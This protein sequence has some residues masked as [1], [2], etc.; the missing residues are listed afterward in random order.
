MLLQ[1]KFPPSPEYASDHAELTVNAVRD[2]DGLHLDYSPDT[3]QHID[4]IIDGFVQD[5]V[6]EDEISAVL[7]SFGCYVGEVLVRTC[8]A[9]WLRTED[10]PMS[11]IAGFPMVLQIGPDDYCNPIAKAFKRFRNGEVDSLSYF[12][13]VF[14]ARAQRF[15]VRGAPRS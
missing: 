13:S 7:F 12:Y 1:L 15:D 14:S 8:G 4:R 10:T 5:G 9:R 2:L 3:I 11:S 6:V